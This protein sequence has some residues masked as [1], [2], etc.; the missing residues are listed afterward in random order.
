MGYKKLDNF[1][2]F[3]G[4]T[5]GQKQVVKNLPRS[6]ELTQIIVSMIFT[7]RGA[8]SGS[9]GA[10]TA[11]CRPNDGSAVGGVNDALILQKNFFK[12]FYLKR[13]GV[14]KAY[15]AAT[16]DM[17]ILYGIQHQRSLFNQGV[18]VGLRQTAGG[19]EPNIV[20]FGSTAVSYRLDCI[21]DFLLPIETPN[22]FC[23][24]TEQALL[25]GGWEVS[26]DTGTGTVTT[27][28][29]T[30]GNVDLVVTS[31]NLGVEISPT[32]YPVWGPLWEF[33]SD[34][35]ATEN[36]EKKERRIEWA[37]YETSLPATLDAAV[38]SLGLKND[39]LDVHF[40]V[41]PSILAE[42]YVR[43]MRP[44]DGC[45]P[46]D[47][48][49]S[50]SP[51]R[52]PGGRRNSEEIELPVT[53]SARNMFFQ[54]SS[55]TRN[56]RRARISPLERTSPVGEAVMSLSGMDPTKYSWRDLPLRFP[57]GSKAAVIDALFAS[58]FVTTAK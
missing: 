33:T 51:L 6:H 48:A 30:S 31:V 12:Q 19:T 50:C 57:G 4:S 56:L 14:E 49:R 39:G 22:K 18:G 23:P 9:Q 46:F 7:M 27:L 54:G 26:Y 21:F 37:L 58:R 29:L 42:Q 36:N 5:N 25:D 24:G 16:V 32:P 45:N 38:T 1:P 41:I 13:D 55:A 44:Y 28:A 11:A 53:L 20:A 10:F 2:A 34:Q 43:E 47:A 3:A 8:T 52:W 40:N 15:N 17:Q 35:E